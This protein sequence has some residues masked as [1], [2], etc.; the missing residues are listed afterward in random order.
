M[1]Q[2]SILF[3]L[4]F[5]FCISN[6]SFSQTPGEWTW[7]GGDTTSYQLPVYG[8]QGVPSIL[9]K[10]PSLYEGCEW[11]DSSGMFW[12]YGGIHSDNSGIITAGEER[13][14]YSRK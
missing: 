2:L 8:T 14:A 11:T 6:F 10:P 9:N 4:H 7:M 5:T 12:Y 1:K 3:I 13:A